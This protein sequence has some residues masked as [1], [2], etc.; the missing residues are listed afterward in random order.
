[1]SEMK[2]KP[3]LL[4]FYPSWFLYLGLIENQLLEIIEILLVTCPGF[5][6]EDVEIMAITKQSVE[7]LMQ[8]GVKNSKIKFTEDLD[9]SIMRSYGMFN[10]EEE[11]EGLV[12]IDHRHKLTSISYL[13]GLLDSEEDSE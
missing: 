12:F 9:G 2:G 8:E 5:G 13:D 6:V 3:I 4:Y 11:I 10:D 1:M 7:K